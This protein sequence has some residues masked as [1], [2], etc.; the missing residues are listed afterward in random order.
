MT[1]RILTCS[2]ILLGL[3]CCGRPDGFLAPPPSQTEPTL[4]LASHSSSDDVVEDSYIVM[5]KTE[6]VRSNLQF[7]TFFDEY[8]THYLRLAEQ[9]DFESGVTSFDILSAVN[10]GV[11]ENYSDGPG[12]FSLTE[13]LKLYWADQADQEAA[14]VMTKINF[15]SEDDAVQLLRKWETDGLLWYAEPNG[16]SRLSANQFESFKKTYSGLNQ[17][18]HTQIGLIDAYNSLAT[19]KSTP[20][21]AIVNANPPVVA[22]LD[23]GV[24]YQHDALKDSIF[25]NPS[26]GAAGCDNDKYGCNTTAP[27]KGSLGNGDVWP[28]GASGPGQPV[29]GKGA[30]GTHVA[31]LIAAKPQSGK[32]FG[33]VCPICK[34][35]ILK[36]AAIESGS[37]SDS[38]GITDDSQIRA[39]KYV[40]R[41]KNENS[42]GVRIINSSFGKYTRSKS[43]AILVDVLKKVGNGTMVIAAASNEDSMIR[44]YPGALANA[45]GVA[46]VDSDGRKSFFSNFGPWVDIAAP[47]NQLVSTVPGNDERP[48]SGTSM[49]SPVTAG[50]AGLYLA[51]NPSASFNELRSKIIDCADSSIYTGT[52]DGAKFNATYYYPQIE[53]ESS[54]RPLLGSGLVNINNMINGT[55]KSAVGKPL[56]RVT[57]GCS[58]LGRPLISAKSAKRAKRGDRWLG[59]VVLIPPFVL[60]TLTGFQRRKRKN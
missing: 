4:T 22:V 58:T 29:E 40:T 19:G 49:A 50:V 48:D 21:D 9:L 36:V 23:S 53:G 20:D 31:G 15:K 37:N 56:D 46:A 57:A 30:H 51:I 42:N 32:S 35:M 38:P 24:D 11:R 45:I 27:S 10:L 43:V 8:Q 44:S 25:Q 3:C 16:I 33:G 7:S 14:G 13:A 6:P 52:S 54:R 34:I 47:G 59:I 28:V 17:S 41:F 39:L 12:E 55:C 60:F 2:L 1:T 26:L 5:F 18:W